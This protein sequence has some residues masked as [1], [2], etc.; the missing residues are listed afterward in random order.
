MGFLRVLIVAVGLAGVL[1]SLAFGADPKPDPEL[2][3]VGDE[4]TAF[5]LQ[6]WREQI[7]KSGNAVLNAQSAFVWREIAQALEKQQSPPDEVVAWVRAFARPEATTDEAR[8]ADRWSTFI[9]ARVWHTGDATPAST[10]AIAEA[11]GIEIAPFG[12]DDPAERARAIQEWAQ[13]NSDGILA[14]PQVAEGATQ[15]PVALATLSL[16]RG[17]WTPFDR[18]MTSDQ[19]FQRADGSVVRVPMMQGYAPTMYFETELFQMVQLPLDTTI[20]D[21]SCLLI[22]PREHDGLPAVEALLTPENF[23]AWNSK[24]LF[25][26][27]FLKELDVRSKQMEGDP[28]RNRA[29]VLGERMREVYIAMP[30]IDLSASSA[31]QLPSGERVTETTQASRLI[32]NEDGVIGATLGT[33][34]LFGGPPPV[35]RA[36]VRADRPFLLVMYDERTHSVLMVVRIDDP[37]LCAGTTTRERWKREM[38]EMFPDDQPDKPAG[39]GL[40][41]SPGAPGD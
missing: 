16:L 28:L 31:L 12:S 41:E 13:Q 24:L 39:R 7:P 29:A 26:E 22:L 17:R 25:T 2:L 23:R 3:K 19:L 33:G 15:S 35:P 8:A 27:E 18:E 40:F 32:V 6:T 14:A 10:Q 20:K 5:A 1:T 37:S 34:G 36:E 30:L 21:L 4:V 38:D 11:M 9:A